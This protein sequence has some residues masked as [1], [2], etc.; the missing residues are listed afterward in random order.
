[1]RR[2]MLRLYYTAMSQGWDE[3]GG[4]DGMGGLQKV[5]KWGLSKLMSEDGM[6]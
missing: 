2:R 5:S 4:W 6:L 1:M 3:G